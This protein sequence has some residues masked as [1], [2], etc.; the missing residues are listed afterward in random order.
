MISERLYVPTK[1]ISQ[2][3]VRV[4]D[5]AIEWIF[6]LFVVALIFGFGLRFD[7]LDRTSNFLVSL[8]SSRSFASSAMLVSAPP[9]L[10][11][12]EQAASDADFEKRCHAAGV[13]KCVGFDSPDEITP[14][15]T[16]DSGGVIRGVLDPDVKASGHGSLRFEIPSRSGQNSSGSWTSGMG[17]AFGEGQTFYVQYR[18]R[19][20]P[21]FLKTKYEGGAG[22]KQS[23]FHM[24]G[25]T[26]ASIEITTVNG[27]YRG[28]PIVYT[29]CGSR[30]FS[31]ALPNSDFLLEQGDSASSGYNCHYQNRSNCAFYKP[32]EWMTFYYE[33]KIG[34]WGQSNSSVKAWVGY[35]G[36]PLK[37]FV[38]GVNYKLNSNSGPSDVFDS[39]SLLPYNTG[40][41]QGKEYPAT[42]TWYDELI[43]SR[44]P[45]PPPSIPAKN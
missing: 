8:N 29:D 10:L 24:D 27:F 26:C 13:V 5:F 35:E 4:A 42:Y 17:A 19:F 18:Q 3:A 43:V 23:I 12:A 44:N 39:I 14:F 25:K 15:L 45:I 1:W 9:N 38:N 40:K 34:N 36:Q 20:T 33:V 22:W 7:T 30:D 16:K 31:V 11:A 21:E 41:S 32:N 6:I 2:A 37:Q 28:F